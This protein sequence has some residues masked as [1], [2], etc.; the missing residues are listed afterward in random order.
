MVTSD[1]I[2]GTHFFPLSSAATSQLP[3]MPPGSALSG[4]GPV[5]SPYS[6][7]HALPR[8]GSSRGETALPATGGGNSVHFQNTFN[9]TVTTTA[10]GDE[11]ELR[12]LGRRIGII[13][14]DEMKRYGGLR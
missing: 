2:R 7:E 8:Y 4:T 12:E 13:L 3:Q 14:S 10:K 9:I 6:L 5:S 1:A 11:K